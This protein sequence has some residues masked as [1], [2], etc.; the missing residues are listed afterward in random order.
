MIQI[1]NRTSDPMLCLNKCTWEVYPTCDL[2]ILVNLA[3]T[4]EVVMGH[5]EPSLKRTGAAN[6]EP[7]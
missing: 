7:G 5:S 1:D 3:D 2:A 6:P 4:G